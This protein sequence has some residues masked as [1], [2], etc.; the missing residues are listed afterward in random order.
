MALEA[1]PSL[2]SND[3]NIDTVCRMGDGPVN[4][5]EVTSMLGQGPIPKTDGES[6]DQRLED[7]QETKPMN[8]HRR[9]NQMNW[10]GDAAESQDDDRNGQVSSATGNRRPDDRARQIKTSDV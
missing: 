1:A 4:L 7:A 9:G 2:A 8:V 10:A 3:T 6:A 5:Q